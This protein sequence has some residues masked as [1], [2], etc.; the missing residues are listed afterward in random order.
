MKRKFFRR[1]TTAIAATAMIVTMMAGTVMAA[2]EKV[3]PITD[4]STIN[5]HVIDG[6]EGAIGTGESATVTGKPVAGA[7]LIYANIG[8]L[9]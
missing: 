8:Q 5:V 2:G 6:S 9:V 7:E 3:T 1:L 4:T